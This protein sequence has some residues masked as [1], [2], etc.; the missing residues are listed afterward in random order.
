MTLPGHRGKAA[1]H[2]DATVRCDEVDQKNREM[3]C[4]RDVLVEDITQEV[5]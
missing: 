2:V 4:C 1:R 3:G 5:Y